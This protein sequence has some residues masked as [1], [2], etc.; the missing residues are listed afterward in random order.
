MTD[1]LQISNVSTYVETKET[2]ILE[3]SNVS[4]YIEEKETNILEISNVSAYIEY[5]DS[6]IDVAQG[7][8]SD[9]TLTDGSDRL[10]RDTTIKQSGNSSQRV[11]V[12]SAGKGIITEDTVISADESTYLI[13]IW[14]YGHSGSVQIIDDQGGNII[15]ATVTPS[16]GGWTKH[17]FKGKGNGNAAK[18]RILSANG[19]AEFNIDDVFIVTSDVY[20]TATPTD[21]D[22]SEESLGLRIGGGSTAEQIINL[23]ASAGI[24]QADFIPRHS[25]SNAVNFGK[26]ESYLFDMYQDSD[27]Y[28][29]AYWSAA[30]T[31]TLAYN[32]GG[33]GEQSDTYDATGEWDALEQKTVQCEYSSASVVLRVD[34]VDIISII[35]TDAFSSG[36][37]LVYWGSKN[38]GTSQFD[39]V[40]L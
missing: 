14:L 34:G 7:F 9:S 20:V 18:I 11:N 2:N 17:D 19:A 40:I 12:N 38:D 26:A 8:N 31:I 25:A 33:A 10:W 29:R 5:R 1:T 16:G 6:Q 30:N 28:I 3:M 37:T 27:N 23:P 35:K 22:D 15:N 4:V 39:G 21:K 32:A 24:L 13:S 36:F